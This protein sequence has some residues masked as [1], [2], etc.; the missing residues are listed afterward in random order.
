MLRLKFNISLNVLVQNILPLNNCLFPSLLRTAPVL[1]PSSLLHIRHAVCRPHGFVC[2]ATLNFLFLHDY[3]GIIYRNGVIVT[4]KIAITH[5]PYGRFM[6]HNATQYAKFKLRNPPDLIEP[7][8]AEKGWVSCFS[9]N[10][11]D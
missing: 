3:Y 7:Y 6:G 9:L 11:S 4:I 2:L 1:L 5:V 8:I 10:L